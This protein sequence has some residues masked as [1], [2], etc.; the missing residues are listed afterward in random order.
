MKELHPEMCA[1]WSSGQPI[2]ICSE[3]LHRV[4]KLRAEWRLTCVV[5]T[6]CDVSVLQHHAMALESALAPRPVINIFS[7]HIKEMSWENM[8]PSLKGHACAT[9]A[10]FSGKQ[11]HG[12]WLSTAFLQEEPFAY[13]TATMALG[14]RRMVFLVHAFRVDSTWAQQIF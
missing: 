2:L 10:R 3:L 13:V 4:T 7:V 1:S 12:P 14:F 5:F 8:C 9:L 11:S 6:V